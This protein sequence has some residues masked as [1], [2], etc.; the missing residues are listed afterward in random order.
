MASDGRAL[1]AVQLL[2]LLSLPGVGHATVWKLIDYVNRHSCTAVSDS[3]LPDLLQLTR[4]KKYE[5]PSSRKKAEITAADLQQALTHAEHL[6]KTCADLGIGFLTYDHPVFQARFSKITTDTAGKD[7]LCSPVLFYK[8]DISLLSGECL[9]VIG[10]RNCTAEAVRAGQYLAR[11]FAGRGFCI[12]SGLA[13]GCDTAAHEGALQAAGGK[14]IAILANGLDSVYPPENTSLARQ[15]IAEGG[16]LLSEVPPGKPVSKNS[17]INRD[18]LQAALSA[19]V[20]VVQTAEA[21]GSMH[22]AKAAH[23]AGRP[24]YA[25]KF[26][27]AEVNADDRSLGNRL[28]AE[29]YGARYIETCSDKTQRQHILNAVAEEIRQELQAGQSSGVTLPGA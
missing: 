27:A 9:A 10:S 28:L 25:V 23:Y 13:V 5:S 20:V 29:N 2:A 14:T 22:A 18:F 15:I 12:V 3:E 7:Y 11:Q 1:S 26:S 24:L 8:G 6:Q 17:L 4:I 21:G 16:L 19:A